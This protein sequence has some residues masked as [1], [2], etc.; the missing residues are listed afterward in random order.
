VTKITD[1]LR[2]EIC[3]GD[4]KNE[5]VIGAVRCPLDR[6]EN[7]EEYEA[8][9]IV[10]DE[11]N[12]NNQKASISA[13]MQFIKS[14]YQYYQE[15]MLKAE[16]NIK[17]YEKNLKESQKLFENLNGILFIY[18]PEPFKFFGQLNT[19]NEF[20]KFNNINYAAA[21]NTTTYNYGEK[22]KADVYQHQVAD[23]LESFLKETLSI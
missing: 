5:E 15:L 3:S 6:V 13:K 1:E 19:S 2:F 16:E 4:G 12:P 17:T 8:D 10:P 14:F 22:S 9:I 18:F 21:G 23:K 20:K 11:N 7:Q